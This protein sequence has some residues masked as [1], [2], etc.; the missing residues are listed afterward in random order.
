MWDRLLC[1]FRIL[2]EQLPALFVVLAL[3]SNTFQYSYS[4]LHIDARETI[5]AGDH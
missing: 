1:F 2:H 3:F 4:P 5:P